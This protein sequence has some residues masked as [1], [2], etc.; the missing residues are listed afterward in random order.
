MIGGGARISRDIAPFCLAT[1]RNA[2]IGLN[3]VGLRRRGLPRDVLADHGARADAHARRRG[4]VEA[5]VLRIAADHGER[6]HHD[7][8][9]EFAM[10]RHQC[11]GMDDATLAQ[12]RAVVNQCGRMNLHRAAGAAYGGGSMCAAA[13]AGAGGLAASACSVC[14]PPPSARYNCTAAS[15][16]FRCAADSDSSARNR[17]RS[18][19]MTSK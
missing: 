8:I 18:L 14:Q 4:S 17:S 16:V 12:P 19:A 5:Q 2:V 9:G 1:E 3:V 10:L 7:T 15:R 13:G 6:V 11:M